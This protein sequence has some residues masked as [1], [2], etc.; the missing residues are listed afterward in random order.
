MESVIKALEDYLS[1]KNQSDKDDSS[2]PD[3]D[4]DLERARVVVEQALAGYIDALAAEVA[5][6]QHALS[7]SIF[8]LN[9]LKTENA[10]LHSRAEWTGDDLHKFLQALAE[11]EN[12]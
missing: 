11:L 8:K 12:R 9:R 1:V 3:R 6:L 4:L 5:S 10:R 2:L 7:N